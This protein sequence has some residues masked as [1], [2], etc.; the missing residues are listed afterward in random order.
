MKRVCL[1]LWIASTSA[2]AD[3]FSARFETIKHEASREEL[4]RILYA[5]PKGGDLHNHLGGA[6]FDDIL[7][8]LATDES[9]NG[10][11]TF[12]TRVRIN[13]CSGGCG[14]PLSYF[15]TISDPT[16][17]AMSPCC[18]EEYEP[19]E[20]LSQAQRADWLSS[21]RIDN[22]GEGRDEFFEA[23]WP[24]IA[25]VLR[26]APLL[27]ELAVKNMERFGDEGLRYVEFQIGPWN[28]AR[29][30]TPLTEDEFHEILAARLVKPDALDTGVSVRFQTNVLRFTPYA[31][32]RVEQSFAFVDRHRDLWVSVNLVGREDNGK[33]YP[34]R[35]LETF[36]KMRRRYPAIGLA[37]HGGEVDE[38]NQH[39][40]DTLLLGANR[41][42]HGTNLI[43]DP[44][45]LL[46]M[47]TGKFAVEVSLVSNQLLQY[48]ESIE[49]HPFPE[50]L[51][52]GIP[53]CLATDDRG[54]WD[55]NMTDEY[56]LAVTSF[57]LSWDEVVH[58]GRTSLE[59][60]FLPQRE[61]GRLLED[62]ER[63]VASFEARYGRGD[64][65][66]LASGVPVRTSGYAR[67]HLLP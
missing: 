16:W 5:V 46:L 43:S 32:E 65:R 34:L 51:R 29:G 47:R 44:D 11:Q 57:N 53:V 31:E 22:D 30:D 24:R 50:Y 28:R 59:F 40:R 41:I 8:Q 2:F 17:D 21:T 37:I 36:R 67:R 42:G 52:L 66:E 19:L 18:R 60:A 27:A 10:S 62:Y 13:E 48:A 33:G 12:R 1:A 39:V 7:W 49:L 38:P 6:A 3:D 54:M 9:V 26:Q 55:S 15:H 4:Y 63:D 56:F 20:E 58:V 64:W 35:F 25:E 45:T 23:I 61:K 14:T